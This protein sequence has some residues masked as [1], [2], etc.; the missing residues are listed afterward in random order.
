MSRLP[1]FSCASPIAKAALVSP[2]TKPPSWIASFS[3]VDV[4]QWAM[5]RALFGQTAVGGRLPVNVP[6]VAALGA[7]LDLA[8]HP[9]ELREA[10]AQSQAKL[11]PAYAALDRAVAD[12]AFPGGVLAVGY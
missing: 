11:Q 6:G 5:G 2:T 7:G 9:V 3:T 8:A 10:D 12:R 4:A 1:Q